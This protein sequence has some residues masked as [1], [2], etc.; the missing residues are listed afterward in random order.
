MLK[1]K[2]G[3]KVKH[4]LSK[5]SSKHSTKSTNAFILKA[6]LDA[7]PYYISGSELA[8]VLGMSRVGVWSRINKLR[9][10]GISIDATQNMGYR[11][12]AEPK[13][14]EENLLNAWLQKH[15]VEFGTL[16]LENKTESTNSTAEHHLNHIKAAEPILVFANQ[17]TDGKGRYNR[18]WISPKGGNIYYSL[19]FLPNISAIKLRLF[20]LYQ[21]IEIAKLLR[22]FFSHE[23]IMI[24]WPNDIFL[25]GKKIGG[26]L[27]E[28][29]VDCESIKSLI[30]GVGLNINKSPSQVDKS[31]I[32]S[33]TSCWEEFRKKTPLHELSAKLVK[34]CILSYTN[35]IKN[36][37]G[38]KISEIWKEY[39][40]LHEK[41]NTIIDWSKDDSW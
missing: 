27:T 11:I 34:S 29:Q 33:S 36:E 21:G 5:S 22:S 1:Y 35:C 30:L 18:K 41:K 26:I 19:G 4:S 14:I 20:T 32:K 40:Y 15:S 7:S 8:S 3:M 16:I 31:L 10:N 9:Q 6:L 38:Y 17:Q 13:C 39:D 24:K 25:N 23:N 37:K 12:S 28:A 2:Q